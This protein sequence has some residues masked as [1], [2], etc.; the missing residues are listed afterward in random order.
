[1]SKPR[2]LDRE[3]ILAV[4]DKLQEEG[5]LDVG[6][7]RVYDAGKRAGQRDSYERLK[8]KRDF[9]DCLAGKVGKD[10]LRPAEYVSPPQVPSSQPPSSQ[11]PYPIQPEPQRLTAKRRDVLEFAAQFPDG[12]TA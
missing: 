3:S 11:Y 1:M 2:P 10:S 7:D 12:F 6:L 8:A 4:I 9:L 5:T